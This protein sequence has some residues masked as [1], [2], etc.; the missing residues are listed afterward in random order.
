MGD[1]DDDDDEE[2]DGDDDDDDNG[3]EDD[4]D[5]DCDSGDDHDYGDYFDHHYHYR[6]HV[7]QWTGTS[8]CWHRLSQVIQGWLGF[9][10]WRHWIAWQCSIQVV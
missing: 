9:G 4:V 8:N 6:S 3:H 5:Y 10:R 1:D 7:Y 2:E